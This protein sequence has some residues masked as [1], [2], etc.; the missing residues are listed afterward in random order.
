MYERCSIQSGTTD[1]EVSKLCVGGAGQ[2]GEPCTTGHWMNNPEQSGNSARAG[3]GHQL[4]IPQ[5]AIAGPVLSAEMLKE[6][7]PK[8]GG[9]SKCV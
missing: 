9:A 3:F 5:T 1:I 8:Q 6:I 7:V 2:A 4:L